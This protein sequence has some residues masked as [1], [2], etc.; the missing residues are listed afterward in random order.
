MNDNL[1]IP[2]MPLFVESA[3]T[4]QLKLYNGRTA[5]TNGRHDSHEHMLLDR[6]W[7]RVE[8]NSKNAPIRDY[9]VANR[10]QSEFAWIA[11]ER[12][13]AHARPIGNASN[14]ATYSDT[15]TEG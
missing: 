1:I 8:R 6:K 7:T 9:L 12:T 4:R 3:R 13:A 5:C 2:H 10:D 15:L 14:T 11:W